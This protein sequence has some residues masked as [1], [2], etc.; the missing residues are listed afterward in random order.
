MEL[1]FGETHCT[2]PQFLACKKKAIKIMEECGNRLSC[3]NLFKKL[4]ILPLISQY[5]LTLLMSVVENQNLSSTKTEN[6]NIDTR[7]R[8]NLYL[9]QAKLIIYQK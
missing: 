1:Y 7:Q 2:V 5:I 9:P 3:T 8:N 4:Q 6:H